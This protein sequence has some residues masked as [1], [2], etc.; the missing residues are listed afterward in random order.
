[1]SEPTLA[2]RVVG[3]SPIDFP[4]A[5]FTQI[6]TAPDQ[7]AQTDGFEWITKQP[8]VYKWSFSIQHEVLKGMTAEAG[9]SGTRSTH[10]VRASI[11]LNT[12]PV[13]LVNGQDFIVTGNVPGGPAFPTVTNPLFGRV[14]WRTTDGESNYH[15]L[16]LQLTKRFS[17]GLQVQ[18]S[19]TYSKTLDDSSSYVGGTDINGSSDRGGVRRQ[20][21]PGPSAFDVRNAFTANFVYDLPGGKMAGLAGKVL[22]GWSLSSII[23]LNNGPPMSLAATRIRTTSGGSISNMGGSTLDLI[24]GGN[25]NPVSGTSIGCSTVTA[26][27]KLGTPDQ[28]YDPCQFVY[29]ATNCITLSNQQLNT[30]NC[31]AGLPLVPGT[32]VGNL[33]RNHMTAPGLANVDFTLIKETRLSK[34]K[35][36]MGLEFRAEVFN[37]FNRANFDQ[38]S[39]TLFDRSGARTAGAGAISNTISNAPARQIQL[40]VRLSF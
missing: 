31:A 23:R 34:L 18:G 13:T 4:R 27:T 36:S 16:R 39:A 24:P 14:R 35:E 2:T 37:L 30:A 21:E 17:K 15:G 6:A 7:P 22:G 11:Q 20:K 33:G 1:V 9:Y 28:Y 29:P 26:G 19:Y 32:F 40:A 38:P 25:Q 3:D 5:Y 8:T 12:T 10:L